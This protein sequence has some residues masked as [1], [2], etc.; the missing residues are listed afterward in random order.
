[1]QICRL[2]DSDRAGRSTWGSSPQRMK[3]LMPKL[4]LAKSRLVDVGRSF[5]LNLETRLQLQIC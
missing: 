3:S 2:D 5:T 4:S 1:M